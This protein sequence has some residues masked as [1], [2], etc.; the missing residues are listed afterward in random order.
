VLD[1]SRQV[2]AGAASHDEPVSGADVVTAAASIRL[3]LVPKPTFASGRG[4]RL[5][6][7]K[8]IAGHFREEVP[9]G[10]R[11]NLREVPE[12]RLR[13]SGPGSLLTIAVSAVSRA[14]NPTRR[15][16]YR[17]GSHATQSLLQFRQTR[18]LVRRGNKVRV[19]F[20]GPTCTISGT[21][22]ITQWNGT[23]TGQMVDRVTVGHR[24][25]ER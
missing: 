10:E 20:T 18:D 13:Y 17:V 24:A 8:K 22:R 16:T 1:V 23:G 4:G 19:H 3:T 5:R 2:V 14:T 6:F 9:H 21:W 11:V 25:V 7:T 12:D 15:L